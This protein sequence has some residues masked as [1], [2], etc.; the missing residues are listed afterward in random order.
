MRQEP[1]F[2]IV[3]S[4]D[5][6][7]ITAENE[8]AIIVKKNW[9]EKSGQGNSEILFLAF[10]MSCPHTQE[11]TFSKSSSIMIMELD[12]LEFGEIDRCFKEATAWKK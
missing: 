6:I 5:G 8:S 7:N 4:V 10:L 9:T 1:K 2:K 3:F 11:Q 12:E